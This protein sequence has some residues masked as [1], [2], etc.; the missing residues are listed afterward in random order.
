[1][2]YVDTPISNDD[3]IGIGRKGTINKPFIL[4][5]PFWTVDTLFWCIPKMNL[6]YIFY[7]LT[8][9]NMLKFDE[10]STLP[11]LSSSNIKNIKV[12]IHNN[13]KKVE[14]ISTILSQIDNLIEHQ[15]KKYHEL[16]AI[17]IYLL[18]TFFRKDR[19]VGNQLIP[20][21]DLCDEMKSGG[22]PKATVE[23]F[24][25][26]NIP[27]MSISDIKDDKLFST[28]KFITE[29]GLNNSSSKI[30][31]SNNI[32]YTMY[33][34]PGIAFT[35]LIDVAIPQS[36]IS[37]E[38]KDKSYNYYVKE[39]LNYSRTNILKFAMTGTQSNLTGEIVKNIKV[40]LMNNSGVKKISYI[41][42]QMDKL[43]E[44]EEK[45]LEQLEN[46]KKYH[47]QQF[48]N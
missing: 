18:N 12:E 28:K 36:V 44:I 31:D 41:L 45:K 34:T 3:S 24:Y 29:A 19:L 27:F 33:A 6:N 7:L 14:S 39:F 40:P 17:K 21:V 37:I 22:T 47:L 43:I 32:I 23:R 15:T 8:T 13:D 38:L 4:K 16:Q 42:S 5:A 35:T 26:G 9:I 25:G 48:F 46:M 2:T 1:M 20:L 30:I 10:G 11:S